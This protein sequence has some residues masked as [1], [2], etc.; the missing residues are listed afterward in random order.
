[1]KRIDMLPFRRDRGTPAGAGGLPRICFLFNAQ[2]HQLMHGITTAAALARS[3]EAEVHVAIASEANLA[4]AERLVARMGGAPIHFSRAGSAPLHRLAQARGSA[5]PP[6]LL[7]L[8]SIVPWIDRFD[9][10]A[11]PERTSLALKRMGAT[12]PRFIH[13]DH[14]AGDREAGI[15][16]RIARF[17]FV[18]MAGEKQRDRFW[19][20]GLIRPG[21]H[22]VV[23]YP[24]F[25]AADLARDPDWRPFA[26]DRPTVLYNPHFA[27]IGSWARFARPLIDAF[28]RQDRFNLIVAPHVRMF[29]RRARRAEGRD[30]LARYAGLPHI[31]IDLGSD[32]SVDMSYTATADVY[33]GDVSSQIYEFIRR[34][35]PCLFLN[36]HRVRWAH[37]ENYAHWRLGTVVEDLPDPVAAVEA[38][39]AGFP[40]FAE[41]QR[42]R[43]AETFDLDG[44]PA[45][46]RAAAAIAGFLRRSFSN[47]TVPEAVVPG[48]GSGLSFG[49]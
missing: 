15:D 26:D 25:E 30:L 38:S 41:A 21:R 32:H 19:R 31:R 34:P 12:R 13:L 39:I 6:K 8:M 28:A 37:D 5:V 16:R 7:T 1:M 24:K 11:I 23:G 18:L 3:G 2:L 29:D 44:P 17:D 36:A 4:F 45:S 22:A 48:A 20:E 47:A 10:V 14:G 33:V 9:A 27:A 35:R 43:F 49:R 40:A 46:T 42:V